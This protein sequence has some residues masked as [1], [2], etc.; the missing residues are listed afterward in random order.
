MHILDGVEEVGGELPDVLRA[1]L[2][3]VEEP[4]ADAALRLGEQ[5]RRLLAVHRVGGEERVPLSHF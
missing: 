2:K 4:R 3:D 1:L 5:L